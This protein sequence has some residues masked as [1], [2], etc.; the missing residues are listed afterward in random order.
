MPAKKTSTVKTRDAQANKPGSTKKTGPKTA[1]SRKPA[2]IQP[3]NASEPKKIDTKPR[4]IVAVQTRE[5]YVR[6][7]RSSWVIGTLFG[8]KNDHP[9]VKHKDD[10]DAQKGPIEGWIWGR[11]LGNV[12]QCGYVEEASLEP[13]ASQHTTSEC[14]PRTEG[15]PENRDYL[16]KAFAVMTNN[17]DHAG[18]SVKT[19]RGGTTLFANFGANKPLDP[20]FDIPEG[21]IVGWRWVT[22][23]S[24]NGHRYVMVNYVVKEKDPSGYYKA[25]TSLWG[26]VKLSDLDE[27][28]GTRPC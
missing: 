10:F 11:A 17:D 23:G 18:T 25:S 19:K 20:I 27:L 15:R 14:G 24:H 26:F 4:G 1:N 16:C 3:A 5:V 7:G 22:K 8:K 6:S 12:N 9:N 13:K 2:N 28:P 21:R